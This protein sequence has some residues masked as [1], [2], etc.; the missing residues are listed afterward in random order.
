M[1]L[2]SAHLL[3]SKQTT[4]GQEE[5]MAQSRERDGIALSTNQVA[6]PW[7][8]NLDL[9]NSTDN[10]SQWNK[11]WLAFSHSQLVAACLKEWSN[12]RHASAQ[13]EA[14]CSGMLESILSANFLALAG[15]VWNGKHWTHVFHSYED[16]M[17]SHMGREQRCSN[18][19][20]LQIVA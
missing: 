16:D 17:K 7:A 9:H 11:H 2:W 12:L 13:A 1:H 15:N 19:S 14:L 18:L 6:K 20:N 5:P 4:G 10:P 8:P 3:H